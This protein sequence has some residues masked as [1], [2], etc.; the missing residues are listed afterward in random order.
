MRRYTEEQKKF[1]R[2]CVINFL[3]TKEQ[4][5]HTSVEMAR[6]IATAW[7]KS[8]G[9]NVRFTPSLVVSI[10]ND[11]RDEGYLI[12]RDIKNKGYRCTCGKKNATPNVLGIIDSQ[13]HEKCRVAKSLENNIV[14][15]MMTIQSTVISNVSIES[16]V[17][18]I[19][20]LRT[21]DNPLD[22][23]VRQLKGL[24]ESEYRLVPARQLGA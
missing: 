5:P 19:G 23:A 15:P 10:I 11:L 24:H 20:E 4:K 13:K 2:G 8:S 9:E 3:D 16:A 12:S 7:R 1:A 21:S 22:E 18:L 17:R 14:R 6:W